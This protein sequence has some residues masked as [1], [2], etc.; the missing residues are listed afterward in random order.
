ML[1][2]LEPRLRRGV[3]RVLV[4]VVLACELAV[5]LLQLV[6][7]RVL[8]DA[9]R[10]VERARHRSRSLRRRR[11]AGADDDP[12]RA[13]HAVAEPVAL[14]EHLDH[15]A[16]RARRRAARA[17]PPACAGRTRRRSR[18]R[19]GPPARARR[20][21]RDGRAGRRPRA[22]PPRARAAASS[23]RSRSST[24]R[25]ELLDEPLGGA[26]DQVALLARDPLAVVVE[27]GLQ[28]LERVE[29]LVALARDLA[30]ARRPP[31]RRL[32]RRLPASL[33]GLHAGLL[34]EPLARSRGLGL[35]ARRRPPRSRRPRSPR[36]P[37]ADAAVAR[38]RRRATPGRRSP[39]RPPSTPPGAR[40]VLA[41]ISATSPD[42]S[43]PRS[44]M[45]RPST[46]EATDSSSLSRCSLSDFS[47]W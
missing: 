25:Q 37:G 15:G 38:R 24:H 11:S 21:A 16:L 20:R 26:R 42:S 5:G 8:R 46:V 2:L 35:L 1:N 13:Q 45:I 22:A 12:R 41:L 17:A 34:L 23:A 3:A 10:L 44:S 18:P 40:R 9:E 29:V 19:R 6:R 7:R 14:L 31:T 30:R 4:R 47:V 28:P 43:T 39:R 36:R 27:L 32:A 33:L